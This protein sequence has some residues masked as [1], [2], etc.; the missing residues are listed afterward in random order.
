MIKIADYIIT[1]YSVLSIEAS[2]L[3]KPIFLYLY[4]YEEYENERGLNI[5]LNKELKTFT[6]RNFNDIMTKIKENTYNMEEINNYR[7]KYIQVDPNN[8]I[9]ELSKFILD[10]V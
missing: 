1:D 5:N 7:D 3:D 10:L 9:N 4:D 8:T 6:S 2:I